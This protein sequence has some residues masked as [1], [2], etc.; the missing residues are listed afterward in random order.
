[1]KD[2]RRIIEKI[3]YPQ[4]SMFGDF[5]DFTVYDKT[6]SLSHGDTA[7]TNVCLSPHTD[8][9]YYREPPG[10]KSLSL[11]LSLSLSHILLIL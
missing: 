2:T 3:S 6:D 8:G 7:Y 11:S 9:T 1:M 5:W 4:S 10:Y